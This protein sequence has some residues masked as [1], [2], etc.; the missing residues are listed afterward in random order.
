[1]KKDFVTVPELNKVFEVHSLHSCSQTLRYIR[2]YSFSDAIFDKKP[3]FSLDIGN[4]TQHGPLIGV[5][6]IRE[7]FGVYVVSH[8]MLWSDSWG[9]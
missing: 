5:T 9:R 4:S 8:A 3:P 6:I 1:M 2:T 7:P